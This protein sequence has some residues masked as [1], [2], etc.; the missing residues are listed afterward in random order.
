MIIIGSII[1]KDQI[2]YLVV[3][4]LYLI[5]LFFG[6]T[7]DYE[8]SFYISKIYIYSGTSRRVEFKNNIHFLSK[9]F[10]QK[11]FAFKVAIF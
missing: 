10:F 3:D 6:L 11:L 8:T 5:I 2:K 1:S 7:L 9:C 4:F